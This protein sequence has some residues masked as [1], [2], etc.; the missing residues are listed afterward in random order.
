M[1]STRSA[2]FS[3]AFVFIKVARSPLL[4]GFEDLTI[5]ALRLQPKKSDNVAFNKIAERFYD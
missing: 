4:V 5:P 1:H 2:F 3:H